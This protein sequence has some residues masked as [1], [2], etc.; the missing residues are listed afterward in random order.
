MVAFWD[1]TA[2]T[3]TL[4]GSCR[5]TARLAILQRLPRA[6]GVKCELST[7]ACKARVICPLGPSLELHVALPITPPAPLPSLH[8]GPLS[9]SQ[10]IQHTRTPGPL[11][12]PPPLPGA[13]SSSSLSVCHLPVVWVSNLP[14]PQGLLL[15]RTPP[16]HPPHQ[17]CLL[18]IRHPLAQPLLPQ[19]EPVGAGSL[20]TGPLSPRSP[21][22]AWGQVLSQCW[23]S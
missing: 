11:H 9:F 17:P 7:A 21:P 20:P 8:H 22:S 6:L 1:S 5:V 14:S 2:Q 18:I 10:H 12:L 19:T 13:L 16:P 3:S 23:L 4:G 15:G